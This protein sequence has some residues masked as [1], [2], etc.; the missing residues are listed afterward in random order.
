MRT[1]F[2]VY[3]EDLVVDLDLDHK[4][5]TLR[6]IYE[7]LWPCPA[8]SSFVLVVSQ[9]D[10]NPNVQTMGLRELDEIIFGEE[11]PEQEVVYDY[12]C[13]EQGL[14]LSFTKDVALTTI[15]LRRSAR[16]AKR[17]LWERYL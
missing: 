6:T 5:H 8:S 15:F 4:Y 14:C 12:Q 13:G 2:E 9:F 16:I 3:H 17:L 10:Q 1:S 11:L 7:C